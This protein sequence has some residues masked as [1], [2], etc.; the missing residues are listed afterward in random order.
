MNQQQ[1]MLELAKQAASHS[2][3]PYSNFPVGTCIRT[4][5]DTLFTGTN[6]ENAAFVSTS[7]AEGAAVGAMITAG[8]HEIAEVLIYSP[9]PLLCAPC[10][11]CRQILREFAT[12]DVPIHLY[13]QAGLHK[14]IT[15]AALLP[16]SFGPENLQQ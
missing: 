12:P 2:Y 9:K 11:N 13:G 3:S 4:T 6:V 16:D 10:G 5:N 15:L 7:C 8:E 1:R 14:T